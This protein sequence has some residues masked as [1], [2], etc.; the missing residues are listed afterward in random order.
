MF[1]G[2]APLL[3]RACKCSLQRRFSF[4]FLGVAGCLTRSASG[5]LCLQVIQTRRAT[6][7]P[8]FSP[9]LVVSNISN[10]SPCVSHPAA[11][12]SRCSKTD[13]FEHCQQQQ[14]QQL[15][16]RGWVWRSGSLPDEHCSWYHGT[17]HD[18][19]RNCDAGSQ[20]ILFPS[21][22]FPTALAAALWLHGFK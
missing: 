11:H 15:Q 14:Q 22:I 9:G 1:R 20:V 7:S 5:S 3:Y 21:C 17:C 6:A 10:R 16:Q 8:P 2:S 18:G 4:S 13:G 12:D 19:D